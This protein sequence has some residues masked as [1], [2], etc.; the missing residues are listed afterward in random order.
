MLELPCVRLQTHPQNGSW[1]VNSPTSDLYLKPDMRTASSCDGAVLCE[2]MTSD[3]VGWKGCE[4]GSGVMPYRRF[5]PA[6]MGE[7]GEDT[8]EVHTDDV[9]SSVKLMKDV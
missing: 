8:R 9:D 6:A 5:V 1:P 2:I 7:A 3:V 4:S